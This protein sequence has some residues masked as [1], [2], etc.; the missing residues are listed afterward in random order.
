MLVH[1]YNVLL[2]ILLKLMHNPHDFITTKTCPSCGFLVVCGQLRVQD[3]KS[4][5]R[6]QVRLVCWAGAGW[7]CAG[8]ERARSLKFLRGGCGQKI[9][10]CAGL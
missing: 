3:W 5:G 2:Q 1:K 4:T 10:T 8:Q 7:K 9:S 6:V